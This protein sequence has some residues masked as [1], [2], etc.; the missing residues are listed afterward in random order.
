MVGR[1]TGTW[2]PVVAYSLVG[3]AFL[4]PVEMWAL[5]RHCPH[6][7]R[8]GSRLQ[9]I[10]PN[11][12]PKLFPF[13]PQ[14]LNRFEKS[15]VILFTLFMLFFPSLVQAYGTWYLIFNGAQLA[16]LGMA[17]VNLAT[18]MASLQFSYILTRHFCPRCVNFSCPLNK[19]PERIVRRYLA[20]NPEILAA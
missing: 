19:A 8:D 14:P 16:F 6:Y 12:F 3:V 11:P 4:G 9:C 13:C 17:G 15:V 1:A 20:K 10:A 2:W 7:A 18:A 5:C